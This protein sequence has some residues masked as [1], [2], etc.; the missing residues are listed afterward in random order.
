[1]KR[2]KYLTLNTARGWWFHSIQVV[3]SWGN[4]ILVKYIFLEIGFWEEIDDGKPHNA[5]LTRVTKG[6][7]PLCWDRK[8]DLFI[9]HIVLDRQAARWIKPYT[10]EQVI[11]QE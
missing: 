7:A 8:F 2:T 5:D 4:G 1:M 10:F 9:D 3:G 11:Y 6:Q